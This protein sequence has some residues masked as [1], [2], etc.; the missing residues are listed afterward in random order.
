MGVDWKCGSSDQLLWRLSGV[1]IVCHNRD[2]DGTAS[3]QSRLRHQVHFSKNNKC[4][5]NISCL[6][7][8]PMFRHLH[9]LYSPLHGDA[10]LR[11]LTN[12]DCD[13]AVK[14]HFHEPHHVRAH[15]SCVTRLA[16]DFAGVGGPPRNHFAHTSRITV[17]SPKTWEKAKISAHNVT[18]NV[19][20]LP[21]DATADVK[22]SPRLTWHGF[23]ARTS[24]SL[25]TLDEYNI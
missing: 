25:G 1:V 22:K 6:R 2:C 21:R 10:H 23:Y 5:C 8:P 14:Q 16:A 24:L 13:C 20:C 17:T 3:S 7:D 11:K 12:V 18:A 4:Y 9:Y 15:L 19:I